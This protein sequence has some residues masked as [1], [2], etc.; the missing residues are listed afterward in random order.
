MIGG[1]ARFFATNLAGETSANAEVSVDAAYLFQFKNET[2]SLGTLALGLR[3]SFSW[4]PLNDKYK[5]VVFARY[6]YNFEHVSPF[7]EANIGYG[8][9]NTF[10]EFNK[11]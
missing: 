5:G 3:P 9:V 8:L 10:E 11:G 7:V 2:K 4:D 1:D 6:Y